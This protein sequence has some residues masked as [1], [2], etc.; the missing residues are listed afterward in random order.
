M[1]QGEKEKKMEQKEM[2][3][4]QMKRLF[5][6]SQGE[7]EDIGWSIN[8]EGASELTCLSEH[9]SRELRGRPLC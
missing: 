4:S 1:V 7:E 5:K 2:P 8:T 6:D 3:L 9:A